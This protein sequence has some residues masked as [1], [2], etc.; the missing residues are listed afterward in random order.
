MKG[1]KFIIIQL[2][3]DKISHILFVSKIVKV[4]EKH[5]YF[6]CACFFYYIIFDMSLTFTYFRPFFHSCKF[7]LALP[8]F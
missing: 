2:I 5:I 3:G 7:L 4:D 6:Y 1:A 8:C